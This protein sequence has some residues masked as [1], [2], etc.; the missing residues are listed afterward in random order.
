MDNPSYRLR[1]MNDWVWQAHRELFTGV[2]PGETKYTE[3]RPASLWV[4]KC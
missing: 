1:L 3:V 4:D 2:R